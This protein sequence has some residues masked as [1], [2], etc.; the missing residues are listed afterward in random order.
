MDGDKIDG[1]LYVWR[2]KKIVLDGLMAEE[3]GE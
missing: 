3:W 1:N 2:F